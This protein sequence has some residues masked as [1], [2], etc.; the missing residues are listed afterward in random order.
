[1]NEVQ[2]L[3]MAQTL[4][5][6]METLRDRP[7]A[8]MTVGEL[9]RA[10]KDYEELV[11][12]ANYAVK[13]EST[14]SQRAQLNG[15]VTDRARE[16]VELQEKVNAIA[17]RKQREREA[18]AR[19]RNQNGDYQMAWY[20]YVERVDANGRKYMERIPVEAPV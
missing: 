18:E 7:V 14:E 9:S 4:R 11:D 19:A 10:L 8:G 17:E 15:Q 20:R 12:K 6:E 13:L 5:E 2:T 16:A 1:M 3:S